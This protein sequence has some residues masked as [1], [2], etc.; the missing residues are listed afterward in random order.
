VIKIIDRFTGLDPDVHRWNYTVQA[1]GAHVF[2]LLEA[3][4]PK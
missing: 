1:R 2:H 3:R 4:T